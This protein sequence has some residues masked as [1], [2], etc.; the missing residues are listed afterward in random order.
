MRAMTE[1]EIRQ[2]IKESRWG[3]L[4]AIDGD[5]PYA[6]EL[7]YASDDEFI[8]CGSMPG[9]RMAGCIKKNP[10]VSFKICYS[11]E[12]MSKFK[13]VIVEA[14]ARILTDRDE[15]VKG[16]RVLYEKLGLPEARIETRADQLMA[17]T[18]K[19]SFY[20]IPLQGLGGKAAGF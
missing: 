18:E 1:D 3:T 10:I 20:R 15:I 6:V 16:L 13:A 17:N 9:G 8:Y 12:D 7:S 5:K 4:I 14:R 2:F 11:S 19:I